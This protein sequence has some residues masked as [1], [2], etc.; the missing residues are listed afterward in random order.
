MAEA[1]PVRIGGTEGAPEPSPR[2]SATNSEGLSEQASSWADLR[3]TGPIGI[4]DSGLGGLTTIEA[5]EEVLG[6]EALVYFGDTARTP[7]GDKSTATIQ[8]FSEEIVDFLLA[9]GAKAILI[10][11]NTV[12]ASAL[13]YLQKRFPEVPFQGIISPTVDY[14]AEHLEEGATVHIIS[15]RVTLNAKAYPQA[16]QARRPDLS[17]QT[18]A[19]PLFVPLVEEGY[20]HT[21]LSREVVR[22]CLQDFLPKDR[23]VH[24]VLACTHYPLLEADIRALW[25]NVT[26]YNPSAIVVPA[27]KELLAARHLLAPGL[28]S[29]GTTAQ[30]EGLP[31]YTFYASDL[32]ETFLNMIRLF[33]D[34]HPG[35]F[36][37]QRVLTGQ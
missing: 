12:S 24:L 13:P 34:A 28:L 3:R 30:A 8:K 4:F 25:P 20:A 33:T 10:A 1:G 16:L 6:E 22:Y 37:E 18:L 35:V 31:P 36:V 29:A 11:C 7:Y 17:F 15:T 21:P 32:S 27:L 19:C 2:P 9:K 23:P 5:M 26:I 14:L